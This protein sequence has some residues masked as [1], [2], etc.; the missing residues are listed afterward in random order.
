MPIV[1][2]EKAEKL[3]CNCT[4]FTFYQRQMNKSALFSCPPNSGTCSE[5]GDTT[6]ATKRACKDYKHEGATT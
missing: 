4:A 5:R 1:Y 6:R 2:I 3:C